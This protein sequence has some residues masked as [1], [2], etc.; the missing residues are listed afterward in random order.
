MQ[1][2]VSMIVIW[3]AILILMLIIEL[4]SM[5][6]TTVWFA[7]GALV[8]CLSAIFN[9]PIW[10]QVVVFLVVSGILLWFTR[11]LAVKY[12]NKSRKKT[13]I[14]SMIDREA[15]VMTDI[16]NLEE[17]GLIKI[18]GIEWT[19]RAER[20]GDEI[21][22]GTVVRVVEVEGVKLIVRPVDDK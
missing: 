7:G 14:E 2:E 5:G 6:L 1:S 13:N 4:F 16:N 18:G 12:F 21:K 19:A 10:L 15:I 22:A 9:A 17:T 8:A 11:P 3:L 20:I